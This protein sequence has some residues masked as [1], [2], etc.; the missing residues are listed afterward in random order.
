MSARYPVNEQVSG[1]LEETA[2]LLHQQGAN[3]FRVHAYHRAAEVIRSLPQSVEWL[4]AHA[5]IEGLVALDGIGSGLARAIEEL[6]R[7]GRL[8]LLER[9]RGEVDPIGSLC[10]VPGIGPVTAE[11]L[12]NDLG[13]GT[14]EELEAAAH[15]GRLRSVRGFGEK[16]LAGVRD[17]LATRL[18]RTRPAWSSRDRDAPPVAELLEVDREYRDK[19]RMGR[20]RTIAPH[21]F[22]PGRVPWLPILHTSRGDRLYTAAYSNTA[23]AHQLGKTRNW[24]VL[25]CDGAHGE[26]QF[27]VVSAET[28]TLRGRRIVRGREAECEQHYRPSAAPGP[29]RPADAAEQMEL[30]HV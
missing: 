11:H 25:Y 21:R 2:R 23:R 4:L 24:V 14:L 17:C 29:R 7:S 16:R 3:P 13:I 28:G 26:H 1:R 20:L 8:R 30:V 6:V 18:G 5:G 22:N 19:A 10:S 9:L 15:D 27:T 12:F